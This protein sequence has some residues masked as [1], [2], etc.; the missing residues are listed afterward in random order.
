MRA[1]SHREMIIN[2]VLMVLVLILGAG[3]VVTGVL[4][5]NPFADRTSVSVLVRNSNQVSKG[6]S[7]TLLGVPI[8]SVTGV[9]IA[10]DGARLTLAFDAS[11]RIP[12]DALVAV[13]TRS[14]L[15][16]PAVDF[17]P[18]GG[19]G[20]MLTNGDVIDGSQVTV[21]T[22]V[23]EFFAMVTSMS[24]L[25]PPDD[26]AG[27]MKTMAVALDGT[28]DSMRVLSVGGQLLATTLNSRSAQIRSMFTATQGYM[29]ELG[30]LTTALSGVQTSFG[31]MMSEFRNALDSAHYLIRQAN[32][33]GVLDNT[34]AFLNRFVDYLLKIASPLNDALT[35]FI[36]IY[37][38]IDQII[39]QINVSRFLNDLL[40]VVSSGPNG[41]LQVRLIPR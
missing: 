35:P 32:L 24:E 31:Q 23:S 17:R 22:P 33:P 28:E 40:S 4:R 30:P 20:P 11:R 8:G 7:V 13:T 12:S 1:R 14:A 36:P 39:P 18:T 2:A 27:L 29:A 25:L 3:Y 38:A 10:G 6:T 37:T 41:A 34:M 21:S 16:E 9:A 15:G 19:T 5:I 26:T